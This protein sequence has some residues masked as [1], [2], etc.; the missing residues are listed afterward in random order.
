[1]NASPGF[2][3]T[4]EQ[5][6]LILT[7]G[8]TFVEAC[9]GAGKTQA[10]VERFVARPGDD[11]RRGVALVSFTNAAVDEAR[12][13]CS[14][15]QEL[16]GAPNYV[17][18]IDGFINR[19][20][21]A[22]SYA[23]RFGR[24]AEFTD[25]WSDLH[26]ATVSAGDPA[27]EFQLDWFQITVD[28]NAYFDIQRVPYKQRQA[29]R[30]LHPRTLKQAN[31][32]ASILIEELLAGGLLDCAYSRL[33]MIACLD[34]LGLR[35]GLSLLLAS[36]FS[37]VI[38]DE[39][40]DCCP[41]DLR[42]L[43]FLI[44]SGIQVVMVG[45]PDQAIYGFRGSVY[46]ETQQLSHRVPAGARLSGNFRSST[47]IC[48]VVN[49]LRSTP[50]VDRAVGPHAT[51]DWPVLLLPVTTFSGH[52][53]VLT[54]L[55]A[56]YDLGADSVL[57]LAH[58]A[59]TARELAGGSSELR[60]GRGRLARIASA[61]DSLQRAHHGT[62]RD[63]RR[64]LT[65]LS[66][67]IRELHPDPALRLAPDTDFLLSLALTPREY[68]SGLLR[69]AH[70]ARPFTISATDYRDALVDT[71]HILDWRWA[72]PGLLPIPT[73]WPTAVAKPASSLRWATVHGHKGLQSE[74]VALAIPEPPDFAV[75]ND[76][77]AHWEYGTENESRRVLYVGASRAQKLL[78]LVV[79]NFHTSTVERLLQRDDVPYKV[80]GSQFGIH[81]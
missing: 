26:N 12:K 75:G 79:A 4:D 57:C 77:V 78:I 21:T 8:S 6:R 54:G 69:L 34:D 22:P 18:T 67:R 56:E 9:P 38:V 32:E 13:R 2:V 76:G 30:S 68:R 20:I 53:G 14:Y 23:M 28:G 63:F 17:G 36:R 61:A 7:P 66:S 24:P 40:Q 65:A 31:A 39:I 43:D 64:L 11:P 49:S 3:F 27:V 50:A 81:W 45:D 37:E 29:L 35:K 80:A 42:L 55:A 74:V 25:S 19:F 33:F 72:D 51:I 59:D 16:L 73:S 52:G 46:Q 10:I 60:A 47:A 71:L 5:K 44:E 62:A 41:S 48:R 70:R 15:A 1:V 58:S